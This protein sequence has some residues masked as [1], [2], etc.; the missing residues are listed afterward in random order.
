LGAERAQVLGMV[1]RRGLA[2]TGAG[3]GAG[4]L[5]SVAGLRWMGG[6]LDAPFRTAAPEVFLGA[7][8]VLAAAAMA[9]SAAPAWRAAR[10]DPMQALRSE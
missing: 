3:L 8:L 5:V 1:L 10:V 4:A 6:A 7:G 9:A 2:M